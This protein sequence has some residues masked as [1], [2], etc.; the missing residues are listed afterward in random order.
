MIEQ[1][2][3]VIIDLYNENLV[4][5]LQACLQV[6]IKTALHRFASLGFVDLQTYLNANGSRISYISGQM[7]KLKIVQENLD[8]IVN[9]QQY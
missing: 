8:F 3:F 6:T 9:L 5:S 4:P 2:H 1:I 7:E